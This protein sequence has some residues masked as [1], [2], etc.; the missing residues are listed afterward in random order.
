MQRSTVCAALLALLIIP[1]TP[2][3][4]AAGGL[5]E[6]PFRFYTVLDGLTQSEVYQI[7][8]DR[9]GY[10][11]FT[12]ARGLNRFDGN[13]FDSFTIADGLPSNE[14]TALHASGSNS[15]WVGDVRGNITAMQG[16]RVVEIIDVTGDRDAAILDIELVGQRIL[17]VAED[18]GVYQVSTVDGDNRIE[19]IGGADA[20][21]T[22]LVVYGT[23][24]WAVAATGLYA[25][26][27]GAEPKLEL[28]NADIRH[29]T[30]DPAGTIWGSTVAG[31]IGT[32]R[33]GVFEPVVEMDAD[34]E[35]VALG[36]S[37]DQKVYAASADELFVFDADM[38][39][40]SARRVS[41][42]RYGGIDQVSA[43]FVDN[44]SSVWMASMS[45]L[46]RFLDD[47]FMH[48][49]LRTG[50]D[51]AT[52]WGITEDFDGRFWFGTQTQLLVL[53]TDGRLTALGDD[54]GVPAGT[55]RDV[56]TD[57]SGRV[58]FSVADQGLFSIDPGD[59]RAI[60]AAETA[61]AE[62][63]DITVAPDGH[64]WY[65]SRASGVF[66][67]APASAALT[68]F[69]VPDQT[70]VYTLDV[71]S[72]GSIWYGADGVG[73][74]RL[75]PGP[76]G[77]YEQ[78]VISGD[79]ELHNRW[80]DHIRLTGVDAAWV[81][82]EEGGVY[83]YENGHFSSHG[84]G[85]PVADQ[86][87]YVI[88]ALPNGTVVVGGEQGLYQ[89]VPGKPGMAHYNQQV[90]FTGLETNVHATYFDSRGYLWIGTVDGAMRMD[91]TR[92]M[93]AAF[94]PTP[95]VL[96]VE[97]ALDR[98][99]ILDGREVEPD[100]L[101]V[102]VEYAAISL[103]NPRG[104]EYSYQ[105]VGIDS[106]WGPTTRNRSVSYPRIPPGEYEFMVR[107]RYPGGEW[108]R[109][110]ASHR[111]TVLPFF[112]QQP[113][114]VALTVAAI[115][116]CI[117]GVMLYRT[118]HIEWTNNRLRKQ[119]EERTQSIEA[120]RQKL[121]DSNRLLSKEIEARSELETRFRRA[122]ENAPIGMGLLDSDGVLFDA[123]PALKNMFWPDSDTVPEV[124]FADVINADGKDNFGSG[125]GQLVAAEL[126]HL[127]E[128][129]E[130]VG[131]KGDIL[132]T[133]VNLSAVRNDSDEFLYSVLQ[134][135][136]VTESLK[137]TVQ[138]EYQASYDEL[139][140]LLNRRA[141]EQELQR[142]WDKA[143]AHRVP[144]YLMFMDLD[145]FK[146]V[147]DT[148]GHSAG[149]QLLRAV[150]EI[151]L[152]SV[153]AND[154]V[155]RL[156][157][158]EFG[159]IL[160]D[161]PTDVAQRIAES[162]RSALEVFRFQWD[163]EVYRI[164]VSVGGVPIEQKVG[165]VN[166]L[167]QLADAACYAAKEAGRNRVHMVAGDKDSARVH[168]GQVRWVQRLREAMDNNRFAIY[169]QMI[170][171][172]SEDI[173]EPERL[174]VL[175][176]L[177]DPESRRL[178]PPGAFLPAAE[179][180]GLSIELDKWVVS[181]LLDALFIH[182]SFQADERNYWI[183]LSGTSISDRR[184]ADF[185]M[186]AIE[187]SPLPPGTINFEIT[188]TAVIRNVAEAGS[189]MTQLR[190]MGCKF[191]LDDFGS[192]LSSF[193]YLKKL[194]VDFLKIDGMFIR[195]LLRDRTD[196]IFVKSIIDIAH[197]LNIKTIV[198]FVEND[199]ILE[200][201]RDLGADYA[202]GFAIG[203]PFVLAPKFPRSINT[204]SDTGTIQTKAG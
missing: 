180:Y 62:I 73:I 29:L 104:M 79:N 121:E 65:S 164:G 160:L 56:V 181:S 76:D 184:F 19:R 117:W 141:F 146:V 6:P 148:S 188:E 172:L 115:L 193:G 168:R 41:V 66:R 48:F 45:R 150:S 166:E 118:R 5:A 129:L 112:W 204:A 13:S 34:I 70:S 11:W 20:G 194:P 24:V 161:C 167:Q 183:N 165:D 92:P 137:L 162:I 127:D 43:L 67:Y 135:Q 83:R 98:R 39:P 202:Q 57:A 134:I 38:G 23:E 96:A 187:R 81:A 170:R 189:L 85:T 74:V 144:S 1:A 102:Q 120:A 84:G 175:L 54:S 133:V 159:I 87:V 105:L 157:G 89:F 153:R 138:L 44:E 60:A 52:V 40:D 196:K 77:S 47:R 69:E 142:A 132:Q 171:P 145:Q 111:F 8:Q 2:H 12:T 116:L 46:I 203:R 18:H 110:Y 75:T 21:I 173:Q 179:R 113:W 197:T 9:A 25:L 176:R 17:A 42:R 97:T 49:R 154:V 3:V 55:V 143:A 90:G 78:V 72:D 58:W 30:A 198:E 149:D 64:I 15:I 186:Q 94:E 33:D 59:M 147:N 80:F 178:I 91:T 177:R 35:I 86:T 93:P 99:P 114:F 26:T 100:Q 7:E 128:K 192:G 107:A 139:T 125:F 155:A 182:Q 51:P 4:S 103:L 169:A 101:G 123:N 22:N 130:C 163:S 82:T 27:F 31:A 152:D 108:S 95:S 14:L 119:V 126:E 200:V 174:E 191:A 63:L 131:P 156:G 32:W 136:D 16:D 88:E 71:A 201:V 190:G 10:L 158:D 50:L 185:L 28:R 195:D 61:G 106:A 199:E 53:D 36:A 151:L 140:G 122:F 68:R 37:R 109:E 124:P